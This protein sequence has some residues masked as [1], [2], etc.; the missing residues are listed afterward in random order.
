MSGHPREAEKVPATG[1]LSRRSFCQG[2]ISYAVH[3]VLKGNV[4]GISRIFGPNYPG[5]QW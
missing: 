3:S 2:A 4:A 1:I 5:N